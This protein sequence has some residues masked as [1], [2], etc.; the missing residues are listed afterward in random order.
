MKEIIGLTLM[1][2]VFVFATMMTV[3]YLNVLTRGRLERRLGRW[4]WGQSVLCS[5]LGA[6]PGCM[7]G[8]AAA[9]F[10]MHRVVS[11]GALLATMVATCGDEA[12]V[13]M[14]LFPR[15]AWLLFGVLFA[16]GILT[17]VLTDL[18]LRSRRTAVCGHVAEYT[19]SHE[20]NAACVPFSI[21]EWASQWRKC[22]P[23]RGWL[24]IILVLFIAG[25]AGGLVGHVHPAGHGRAG[26]E[27]GAEDTRAAD[28]AAAV[29]PEP[30]GHEW[31][32][33]R[34]ALLVSGIVGLAIVA[35]VPDHFLDE[36]IWHHLVKVHMWRIFLWTLGAL[37]VTHW[38]IDRLDVGALVGTH[39][40]PVLLVAVAVGLI[41]ESGPHL[42]FT[43]LYAGGAIPFSVLLANS[44]VQDG[45]AMLP[46]ISHSRRAFVAVKLVKLAIGLV[47]GLLGMLA[48]W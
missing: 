15:Q 27:H 1:V 20:G 2:T 10:Y 47:V 48:G 43:T 41:P 42:I 33:V 36:H 12:Y 23:H 17:G 19:A 18:A 8:Y 31:D 24:T 16:A 44:V 29:H 9:G 40:L 39:R 25:V 5:F 35:T 13:M 32:W 7:G 4:T 22:T 26:E 34:V 30:H 14:V 45:H 11:F 3:E 46:V 21:R 38:L 28:G 37:I 6:T